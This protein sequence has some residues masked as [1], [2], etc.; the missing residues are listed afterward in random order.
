MALPSLPNAP[1]V[2][3][4]RRLTPDR[5][6]EAHAAVRPGGPALRDNHRRTYRQSQEEGGAWASPTSEGRTDIQRKVPDGLSKRDARALKKIRK[7]AHRLDEG[8]SLCGFR[9]GYT[10]FIGGSRSRS[11]LFRRQ[12]GK[13]GLC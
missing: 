3:E 12:G 4:R 5:D 6:E 10:F 7:R 1:S 13:E 8:M 9:V 2:V 11:V